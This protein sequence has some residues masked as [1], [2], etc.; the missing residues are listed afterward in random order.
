MRASFALSQN[1]FEQT[2]F[3]RALADTFGSLWTELAMTN[4]EFEGI[5]KPFLCRE[6]TGPGQP[7]AMVQY[8]KFA[9]ELQRY[10]DQH[11]TD[12]DMA[13]AMSLRHAK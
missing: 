1:F 12:E 4:E 11:L 9:V 13:Y 3:Q 7:P 2:T 10:A 8:R 6:P 5:C